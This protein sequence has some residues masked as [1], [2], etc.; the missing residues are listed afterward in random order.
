MCGGVAAET[1]NT[2]EVPGCQG[3][4]IS[5]ERIFAFFSALVI[6]AALAVGS[7]F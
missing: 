4:K 5:C 6:L 1:P 3:T 2:Y 7:V